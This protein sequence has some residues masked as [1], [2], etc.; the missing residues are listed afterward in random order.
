[1]WNKFK[2]VDENAPP[3]KTINFLTTNLLNLP[4]I[5]EVDI[6]KK[7]YKERVKWNL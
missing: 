2:Q 3:Q 6:Q 1:M 7:L 4:L 5:F